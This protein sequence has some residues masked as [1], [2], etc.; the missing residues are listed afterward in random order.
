MHLDAF[1][2]TDTQKLFCSSGKRLGPIFPK[3][4]VLVENLPIICHWPFRTATHS[5]EVLLTYQEM[6]RL[7]RVG[8]CQDKGSTQETGKKM[9]ERISECAIRD[10]QSISQFAHSRATSGLVRRASRCV[11][12]HNNAD[13]R[14]SPERHQSAAHA[15]LRRDRDAPADSRGKRGSKLG[16]LV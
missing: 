8:T 9:K 2:I 16:I 10:Q 5:S 7:V 12:L 6:N 1:C 3:L 14:S 11:D 4:M 15:M 13:L